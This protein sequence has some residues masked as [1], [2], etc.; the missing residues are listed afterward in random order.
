[1]D[2]LLERIGAARAKLQ[3]ERSEHARYRAA[4]EALENNLRDKDREAEVLKARIRDMEQE[5]ADLRAAH[6]AQLA[7][8]RAGTKE[9]I[10][11]LV[12][13]IDQCQALLNA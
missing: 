9:K 4:C 3:Q 13:E 1:M 8:R 5:I 6:Q 12:N 2:G 10:D 7:E 11:E